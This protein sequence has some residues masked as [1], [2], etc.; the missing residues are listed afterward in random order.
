M[1][2]RNKI[3]EIINEPVFGREFYN[4][5]MLEEM[6]C[7]IK[8]IVKKLR[9][10]DKN[11]YFLIMKKIEEYLQKNVTFRMEYFNF[12]D[13]QKEKITAE[14]LKYRTAYSALIYNNTTC[15]G[16]CEAVR[17]LLSYFNIES[18]TLLAKLPKEKYKIMHYTTAV[19]FEN[20]YVIIDPERR[21]YCQNKDKNYLKYMSKVIYTIPNRQWEKQKITNY[22]V[23]I[24]ANDYLSNEVIIHN[25]NIKVL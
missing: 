20:Y 18:L 13:K 8:K 10:S 2:Y 22:G 4:D 7:E 15:Y 11:D 1:N 9:I 14:E 21:S 12:Y 6:I 23:G 17:I 24:M 19:R 5:L 25:I 3:I 16:Y